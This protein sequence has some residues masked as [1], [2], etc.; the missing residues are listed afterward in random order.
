MTAHEPLSVLV[1]AGGI[2]HERDVSLRSGRRVADALRA[3]GVQASLRDPDAT[4][5][6]FLRDT[7]PAVVWPVLHGASGEDGALLG[8]LE[9]AGVPYVGSSARSARL[10]WDKPTAK[11][12]AESAGIR[13][14]RS[15]T[16]P[17]DTFRELGAAA[18]LRLVTEAV[19][20]PY[21]VKPARGGSAQGVTI[22][23][24]AEALP[25]AMV[26]AY[27]YG[28]VALIEQ[29]VEGTEVAIGVLDTGDGPEALPATEIVPTS[30]VY[31]YE[32]RYN[33][34]LTRFFTPARISPDANAA[35][36][37]AAIGIHRALGIG[38]MSRVDIIIDAAGEPWFIEVNVIPGLTETSLL[39]QGLAAAGVEVGD[40]Y[41]RLAEAARGASSGP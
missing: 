22:V 6:D 5:L 1:L 30:G 7:P 25:R 14:P 10:A 16:L 9:L 38:Q 13:T 34:G 8:L 28:D 18:V 23:T 31:G 21:A 12:I 26:D 15:V 41:R 29:L 32:A 27:T 40:L 3:A 39:P 17:K 20:A 19:P 11:A 2:S 37:A 35:A 24:D 33:A 36:S 4:L